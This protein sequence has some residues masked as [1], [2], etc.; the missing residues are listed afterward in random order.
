MEHS[1]YI[2]ISW[3]YTQSY[4]EYQIYLEQVVG[5]EAE[6]TPA[7]VLGSNEHQRLEAEFLTEAD[8]EFTFE[9]GTTLGIGSRSQKF[10]GFLS[11]VRSWFVPPKRDK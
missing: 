6:P 1:T 10:R 2:S 9:F 8:I 7:M 5:L 3:L 11:T 4:C